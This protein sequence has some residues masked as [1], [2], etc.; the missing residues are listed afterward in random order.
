[1]EKKYL[2]IK[3]V[4]C[5]EGLKLEQGLKLMV[6]YR[7]QCWRFECKLYLPNNY[8]CLCYHWCDDPSLSGNGACSHDNCFYVVWTIWFLCLSF[9]LVLIGQ[10][11]GFWSDPLYPKF[12]Y[13]EHAIDFCCWCKLHALCLW[14]KTSNHSCEQ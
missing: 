14:C 12:W 13:M 8:I 1:M 7:V 11:H 6:Q 3:N 5:G 2:P 9:V 10:S 4:G